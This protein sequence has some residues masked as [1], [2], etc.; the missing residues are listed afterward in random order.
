MS[1]NSQA[2]MA[3]R[4]ALFS[5]KATA[6]DITA[7]LQNSDPRRRVVSGQH[8]PVSHQAFLDLHSAANTR[9]S[10]DGISVPVARPS[11]GYPAT[12]ADLTNPG[13]QL[14]PINEH[15]EI[16]DSGND[17][18]FQNIYHPHLQQQQ[19]QQ[20]PLLQQSQAQSQQPLQPSGVRRNLFSRF[21]RVAKAVK[22]A[23][24]ASSSKSE[25]LRKESPDTKPGLYQYQPQL[26]QQQ[27]PHFTL[28]P[29]T[30]SG[31]NGE[32]NDISA[33][34]WSPEKPV[35]VPNPR[36]TL[37]VA[38]G[39]DTGR[40]L[41]FS[42]PGP[43]QRSLTQQPQTLSPIARVYSE[44]IAQSRSIEISRGPPP[45]SDAV[46]NSNSSFGPNASS[47]STTSLDPN[48][49]SS[50]SRIHIAHDRQPSNVQPMGS[51]T[52][53]RRKS[54]VVSHSSSI[55]SSA[56]AASGP[57]PGGYQI[58][59]VNRSY[60]MSGDRHP[61][62]TSPSTQLPVHPLSA[63]SADAIPSLKPATTAVAFPSATT[64][65]VAASSKMSQSAFDIYPR[66]DRSM[67]LPSD[68]NRV[69][70]SSA[71]NLSS[72]PPMPP[73]PLPPRSAPKS[74]P[75]LRSYSVMPQN[76]VVPQLPPMLPCVGTEKL[77]LAISG[78][79]LF[80]PSADSSQGLSAGE[81][82]HE[83]AISNMSMADLVSGLASKD[84]ASIDDLQL[85][86]P[87]A[88]S[89]LAKS[90]ENLAVDPSSDAIRDDSNTGGD[91]F[92][93]ASKVST[94]SEVMVDPPYLSMMINSDKLK[95]YL[96]QVS[97]DEQA[98][99]YQA[100]VNAMKKQESLKEQRR[101]DCVDLLQT[102]GGMAQIDR[103][104]S[105]ESVAKHAA[106]NNDSGVQVDD[107]YKGLG[108]MAY[109][110]KSHDARLKNS[111]DAETC[112]SA[113]ISASASHLSLP[114]ASAHSDHDILASSLGSPPSPFSFSHSRYSLINQDGSLNLASFQ[115]D[116]LDGYQKQLSG[117]TGSLGTQAGS[118]PQRSES[119]IADRLSRRYNDGVSSG[120]VAGGSSNG[121][122]WFWSSLVSSTDA[123]E[124][125]TSSPPAARSPRLAFG[126][127]GNPGDRSDSFHAGD[128]GSRQTKLMRRVRKQQQQQQQQQLNQS[129]AF[130]GS[131]ASGD[132]SSMV[133]PMAN[134]SIGV[135]AYTGTNSDGNQQQQQQRVSESNSSCD[136][137][138][139]SGSRRPSNSL[140]PTSMAMNPVHRRLSDNTSV[141]SQ[142]SSNRQSHPLFAHNRLG[143][144]NA[145]SD[146]STYMKSN[147]HQEKRPLQRLMSLNSFNGESPFDLVYRNSMASMSLEQALTLVEGTTD[148]E[149]GL[150]KSSQHVSRH[151]RLHKRSA[152]ALNA[153][154]LDDIMIQ[155][156]EMCHSIQT[157]IRMQRSSES[158][159]GGWIYS[160]F[161]SEL[162]NSGDQMQDDP[163]NVDGSGGTQMSVDGD[164]HGQRRSS[165]SSSSS[166]DIDAGVS[167]SE[168]AV[169]ASSIEPVL[170]AAPVPGSGLVP[171]NQVAS[172]H[173]E[174]PIHDARSDEQLVASD[175]S[176]DSSLD[177][178]SIDVVQQIDVV[179]L[180]DPDENDEEPR[181][182]ALG[183]DPIEEESSS[184]S[185]LDMWSGDIPS[186]HRSRHLGGDVGSDNSCGSSISNDSIDIQDPV[187]VVPSS[188]TLR[189]K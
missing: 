54:P 184:E 95:S 157:A 111:S 168:N 72:G 88:K 115:F 30:D 52:R 106:A 113:S 40:I 132:F 53:L 42:Q 5:H 64:P 57:M 65:I 155:T 120:M 117:S 3:M 25:V 21:K 14:H 107:G 137:E 96:K 83:Q 27:S 161:G 58:N 35:S 128:H 159:L 146:C 152:S 44:S 71:S 112:T 102:D 124:R 163:Q 50:A 49:R 82:I 74:A 22:T 156:A 179:G 18:R 110:S 45:S 15:P 26:Q 56:S 16:S 66:R 36:H 10:H 81:H 24:A 118:L 47:S 138:R 100:M 153:N 154:E 187:A 75:R 2:D 136:G 33:G 59:A 17:Y 173:V 70:S 90:S 167:V 169:P 126:L 94:P 127:N 162:K 134:S 185:S 143:G 105:K 38:P 92:R 32:N 130:G 177:S 80:K 76:Q 164:L 145:G 131:S 140:A 171:I 183:M 151:R 99:E 7:S 148:I 172:E 51:P 8:A 144:I 41:P 103:I 150:Q 129:F 93:D 13:S 182:I 189:T 166:S 141:D 9:M 97:D 122:G 149:S 4:S 119:K 108:A 63:R 125:S 116:Q 180:S 133:P 181:N 67:T 39:D 43:R 158:G 142:H 31:S 23:A 34:G 121:S 147:L 77:D 114:A 87:A 68:T 98:A 101:S 60:D 165:S 86:P 20:E 69:G 37:S 178:S 89:G 188:N 55:I 46:N 186:H 104:D 175:S 62:P 79:P 176:L 84:S 48:S 78:S 91:A 73:P 160:V 170:S 29:V 1:K 28:Y 123:R 174:E 19:Q 135:F 139:G 109:D 12:R 6:S 61:R 85:P 11:L